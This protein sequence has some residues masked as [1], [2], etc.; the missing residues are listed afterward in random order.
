M[1]RYIELIQDTVRH[2]VISSST[3]FSW[4]GERSEP[5]PARVRRTLTDT[6]AR[7]FLLHSLQAHLYQHCYLRGGPAVPRLTT[8]SGAAERAI[9]VE[10]L[11]AANVTTSSESDGWAVQAVDNGR[12]V[13]ARA[14]VSSCGSATRTAS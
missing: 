2:T 1:N 12:V 5:V 14:T 3:S 4:F 8:T 9:F 7:S 6:A 10:T 11:S 13:V